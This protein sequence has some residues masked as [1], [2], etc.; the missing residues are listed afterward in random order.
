MT[1][2]FRLDILG[3][4]AALAAQRR[5]NGLT[6]TRDKELHEAADAAEDRAGGLRTTF[7]ALGPYGTAALAAQ[8]RPKVFPSLATRNCGC[9]VS[10]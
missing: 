9:L 4:A 1:R 10:W 7:L 8:R 2:F 5:P 3:G 6:L